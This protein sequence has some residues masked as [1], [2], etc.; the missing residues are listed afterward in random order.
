M[1]GTTSHAFVWGSPKGT[2]RRPCGHRVRIPNVGWSVVPHTRM[3]AV[4][5][6]NSA[7]QAAPASQMLSRAGP[8]LR[9][10]SALRVGNGSLSAASCVL[11]RRAAG[12]SG[13]AGAAVRVR[14]GT[15]A[16]FLGGCRWSGAR[17]GLRQSGFAP[18]AAVHGLGADVAAGV[19][20]VSAPMVLL[21][22]KVWSEV[23]AE[24]SARVQTKGALGSGPHV[25]VSREGTRRE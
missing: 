1:Y 24:G 11:G 2:G 20:E 12:T 7:V 13:H 14:S 5:A 3:V 8:A 21:E 6:L 16:T 22:G 18:V 4:C 17:R 23:D 10:R 25:Y 15:I 9:V 19:C